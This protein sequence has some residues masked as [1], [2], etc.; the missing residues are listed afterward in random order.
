MDTS[1]FLHGTLHIDLSI[2]FIQSR[3]RLYKMNNNFD[4]ENE[5]HIC[6][7]RVILFQA[8]CIFTWTRPS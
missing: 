8:K 5:N 4:Y 6:F 2:K 1:L 3:D 7:I